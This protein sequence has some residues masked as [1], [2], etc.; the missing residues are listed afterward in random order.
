MGTSY[1][2]CQSF[3]FFTHSFFSFLLSSLPPL[4]WQHFVLFIFAGL[5]PVPPFSPA[6]PPPSSPLAS[7]LS[8]PS[9]HV[10]LSSFPKRRMRV[11]EV[12]SFPQEGAPRPNQISQRWSPHP[13]P[14]PSPPAGQL[15]IPHTVAPR[16]R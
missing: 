5:L 8:P 4:L 2:S 1:S 13:P 6:P 12:S 14:P 15:H 16:S 11:L 10:S 7:P 9:A 3:S